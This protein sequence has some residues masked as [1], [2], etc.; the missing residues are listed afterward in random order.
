MMLIVVHNAVP[1]PLAFVEGHNISV[2]MIYLA[3]AT[4]TVS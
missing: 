2:Q 4:G 1:I 3:Q